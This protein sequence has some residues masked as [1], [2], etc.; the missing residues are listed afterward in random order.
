MQLSGFTLAE[1][2][3]TLGVIGVVAA[4]TLPNLI[5]DYKEKVFVNSAKKTYSV[6]YNA[7]NMW[8]ANNGTPG[9][10]TAFWL[11]NSDSD[12]L[13]KDFATYLNAVSVCTSSNIDKC[14]GS[15]TV[16]QYKKINNGMGSTTQSGYLNS[17]RIVLADGSFVG[18]L[19][20]VQAG[21]CNHTWFSNERD[22]NGNYI[23]DPSSPN[24][25]KGEYKTSNN[26]GFFYIDTNGLK[27]PNQVGIDNFAF[28]SGANKGLSS[29]A[30]TDGNFYYVLANGKLIETENY[31]VGKF[32]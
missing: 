6:V 23:P 16:R 14:G 30:P 25:Y 21:S 3:I 2:L 19:S 17:R 7:L 10:Y 13:L 1:V 5:A 32:E 24:G 11:S 18:L 4:L 8:L 9:D 29:Q 28:G 20:E 26:C 27:G 31:T 15:Y 22:P 12:A